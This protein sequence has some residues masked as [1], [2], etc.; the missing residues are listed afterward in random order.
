LILN[1]SYTEGLQV[2]IRLSMTVVAKINQEGVSLVLPARLF[3][4]STELKRI[5]IV[6]LITSK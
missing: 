1:K 3:H 2:S 4:L 5:I 6:G